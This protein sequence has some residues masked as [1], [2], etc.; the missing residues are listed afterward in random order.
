[1]EVSYQP[2]EVYIPRGIAVNEFAFAEDQ[3]CR[4]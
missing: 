1:M 3:N 2:K 4:K